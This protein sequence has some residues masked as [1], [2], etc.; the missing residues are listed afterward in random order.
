MPLQNRVTPEGDFVAHPSR[1]GLFMGNRG[2]LHDETKQLGSAR[3]RHKHWIICRLVFAGRQR[4]M[5]SKGAYTEL[6]FLDEAVALAAGHR[7]CA[8]CRREAFKAFQAAFAGPGKEP[9]SAKAMD[10]ALHRMRI[11]KR[12]K[13]PS[14]AGLAAETLPDGAFIRMENESW[15]ILGKNRLRYRPSGY[16]KTE[17]RPSGLVPVLTPLP[18]LAALRNGYR[19]VLHES[20]TRLS[21]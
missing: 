6:F 11:D 18:S 17:P 19:P 20:A 3:W 4:E 2:I 13:A 10:D 7:P 21:G 14:R 9:M 8:E 1:S 12:T 5:M 15:L 16:D